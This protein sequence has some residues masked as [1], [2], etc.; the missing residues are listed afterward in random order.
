MHKYRRILSIL[1]LSLLLAGLIGAP[2]L[3]QDETTPPGQA[4]RLFPPTGGPV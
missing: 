3:A 2:T 1:F 4:D